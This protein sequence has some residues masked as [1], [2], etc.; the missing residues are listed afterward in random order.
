MHC[1]GETI[2]GRWCILRCMQ[3]LGRSN[4]TRRSGAT[5]CLAL[6]AA[7]LFGAARVEAKT[8][9]AC[10]RKFNHPGLLTDLAELATVRKHILAG[11]EPWHSAFLALQHSQYA[12]RDYTPRPFEVVSS[13]ILGHNSKGAYEEWDDSVAAY[14]QT[15]LWIFTGE[16]VFA[17]NAA[18]ILDAWSSTLKVHQGQN[19]YLDAAWTGST[20]PLSAELLR[21]TYPKWTRQQIAQFSHMLDVAFLPELHGLIAYGNRE[22][23]V[24]NAMMAIGVFNDDSAAFCEGLAHWKSYVPDYI[25]LSSDGPAP[26]SAD[27]WTKTPDDSE[28]KAM[29]AG[30][31]P[32]RT[33][34]IGASVENYGDDRGMLKH[35]LQ[36]NWNEPGDKFVDGLCSETGRDLGHAEMA[37]AGLINAAEIARHQGI[38]LYRPNAK[39]L[40]AFMEL[41]AA[42]RMGAQLPDGLYGGR[43][44]SFSGL[45]PAYDMAYGRLEH[46]EG[47]DLPHTK[48]LLEN[49]VRPVTGKSAP[50]PPGIKAS[51]IAG[52]A[53]I[54]S[55][56]MTL[57]NAR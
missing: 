52:P 55:V 54:T 36:Q 37:F 16:E 39:R 27:Y 50:P 31:A 34:W 8:E 3:H 25:Y 23:A 24:I 41:H 43:P 53:T 14:T 22:F 51:D 6:I 26:A 29:D 38:D 42:L 30:L 19:W 7:T 12:K 32:G 18:K 47:M 46:D 49:V 48:A 1:H 17:Q 35:T 20:F 45:I 5:L 57:T 15:L 11:D 9:Q 40:A 21:A 28:L 44:L 13:G 56:W 10:V 4:R 2:R 33:D